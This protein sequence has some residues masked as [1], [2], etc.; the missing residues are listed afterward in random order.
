MKNL[1]WLV[2]LFVFSAFGLGCE[3]KVS[4]GKLPAQFLDEAQRFIGNFYGKFNGKVIRVKTV[5]DSENRLIVKS[6]DDV[7]APFLLS[8]CSSRIGNLLSI[9]TGN[10]GNKFEY[11]LFEFD[12][13]SCGLPENGLRISSGNNQIIAISLVKKSHKVSREHCHGVDRVNRGM[14]TCEMVT[15]TVVDEWIS[16]T[17]KK[18]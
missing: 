11:A 7:D 18:Y 13:K 14:R 9:N 4:D 6:Y 5:L 2:I 10:N 17:F 12:G 3:E 1:N 8:G 16:G 15:E